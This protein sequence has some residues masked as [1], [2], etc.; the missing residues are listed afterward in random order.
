[1]C[2]I[3]ERLEA[4]GKVEVWCGGGEHPL[5]GKGEEE[6]DEEL[7]KGVWEAMTGM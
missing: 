3:L 4:P 5:R 2:L 6:W 7:W 1:M